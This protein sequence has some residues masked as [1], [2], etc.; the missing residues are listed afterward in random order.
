MKLSKIYLI[1]WSSAYLLLESVKRAFD[2]G[3]FDEFKPEEIPVTLETIEI[4][5]Q[6]LKPANLFSIHFQGMNAK[7]SETIPSVLKL[8]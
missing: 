4:Y 7:H 8:I 6:V 5:L 1:R 2:G 3:L